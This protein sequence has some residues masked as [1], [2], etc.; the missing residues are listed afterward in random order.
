MGKRSSRATTSLSFPETPGRKALL[1]PRLSIGSN[2]RKK[3]EERKVQAVVER[4]DNV[5]GESVLVTLQKFAQHYKRLVPL[6]G[7]NVCVGVISCIA[8]K[9]LKVPLH[10]D[11]V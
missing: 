11:Y 2:K 8:L 9:E 7:L 5:L 4:F 3:A 10:I 1:F 6:P